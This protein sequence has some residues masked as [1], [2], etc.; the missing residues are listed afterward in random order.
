MR[1]L[2]LRGTEVGEVKP[3]RLASQVAPGEDASERR[4]GFVVGHHLLAP[5]PPCGHLVTR[6][7][8]PALRV[9]R[10]RAAQPADPPRP[11]RTRV[12]PAAGLGDIE[13]RPVD[14]HSRHQHQRPLSAVSAGAAESE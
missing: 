7:E 10:V 2:Y 11:L 4:Q 3:R 12:R 9:K 1:L 5:L 8:K 13:E 14:V 6:R